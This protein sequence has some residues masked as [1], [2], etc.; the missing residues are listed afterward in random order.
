MRKSIRFGLQ[1]TPL[2]ASSIVDKSV[3]ERFWLSGQHADFVT[4]IIC[5][6]R[7]RGA[8]LNNPKLFA[9]LTFILLAGSIATVVSEKIRM[10]DADQTAAVYAG[11]DESGASPAAVVEEANVTEEEVDRVLSGLPS[12]AE[13]PWDRRELD[14]T[15]KRAAS[16][17]C[18]L[19]RPS[20]LVSPVYATVASG[21]SQ[22]RRLNALTIG[23]KMDPRAVKSLPRLSKSTIESY[24]RDHLLAVQP[25]FFVSG[26]GSAMF[27]GDVHCAFFA[28]QTPHSTIQ[29]EPMIV[30]ALQGLRVLGVFR[31]TSENGLE[32]QA[33]T[34]VMAFRFTSDDLATQTGLSGT[35]KTEFEL[36]FVHVLPSENGQ[37]ELA[38]F[39][40]ANGR[41]DLQ[42]LEL[43]DPSNV[44]S[45]PS[46]VATI[47]FEEFTMMGLY[48]A[49]PVVTGVHNRVLRSL[50]VTE[51]QDRLEG[52]NGQTKI[53]LSDLL[54]E[55]HR[56]PITSVPNP[57]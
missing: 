18:Q 53:L 11:A 40:T 7:S 6:L 25:G 17:V 51:V 36:L 37:T 38:V 10:G 46:I 4:G 9:F 29:P 49:N 28:R 52:R 20:E 32:S 45:Y 39:A 50:P 21:N 31:P 30:Q 13:I 43:D 16:R 22:K 8:R 12:L 26:Q 14:K 5:W 42:E 34:A 27:S 24:L 33:R 41:K 47:R 56:Q 15:F 44:T 3:S 19:L 55:L 35:D 1:A 54:D 48:P 23:L 57:F 2:L